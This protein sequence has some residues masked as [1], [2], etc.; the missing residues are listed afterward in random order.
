MRCDQPALFA[1][2]LAGFTTLGG[3]TRSSIYDNAS[4]VVV[5]VLRGRKRTENEAFAAFRGGL[6]LD[7][8]F[9]APAKG[10][11]KGG[12]EDEHGY[13][14][15]NFYGRLQSFADLDEL[16][17]ALVNICDA[18]LEREHSTHNETIGARF[19]R[20]AD[21]PYVTT[22]STASACNMICAYQ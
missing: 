4:S 6:A 10:N 14:E 13:I 20:E 16:N 1:G 11:E 3:L 17:V 2:L 7:V 15:D 12:V 5:R 8:T 22:G 21:A 9:A 19:A 18:S